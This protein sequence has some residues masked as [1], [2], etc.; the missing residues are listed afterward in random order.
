MARPDEPDLAALFHGRSSFSRAEVGSGPDPDR[1][2]P[3][4]R[5]FA[6]APRRALGGRDG[7]LPLS[8]GSV[9]AR[10]R[11]ARS[12]APDSLAVEVLGRLLGA[13]AVIQGIGELEGVWYEERPT[14]SAG[15]L[16]PL[17]LYLSAR[18][19]EGLDPGR[20]HYD[21][22]THEL[23]H[24][25]PAPPP[26]ALGDA[27]FDQRAL[28]EAPAVL[29][30]VGVPARSMWKYGQRGYRFVLLEAGHL[31]QQLSLS[32]AALDLGSLVVGGFVDDE[33]HGLFGLDGTEIALCLVAVGAARP[34]RPATPS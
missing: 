34:V 19:V 27:A 25:G 22:Q 6:G 5:R 31:A 11:S 28:D 17:E 8:F 12:F 23:E 18:R 29:A 30:V 20:Y 9:V 24:L 1:R 14:P 15:A 32:A 33:V 3:A 2:P 26:G 13:S 7:A 16:H 21:P 4:H 10:R